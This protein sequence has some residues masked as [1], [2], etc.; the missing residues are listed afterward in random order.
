MPIIAIPFYSLDGLRAHTL[1]VSKLE[2]Q[3]NA[4]EKNDKIN[5]HTVPTSYFKWYVENAGKTLGD[6]KSRPQKF[7]T[8]FLDGVWHFSN[9]ITVQD[10]RELLN[11]IELNSNDFFSQYCEYLKTVQF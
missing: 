10:A 4:M 1:Y 2:Y 9:V 8:E 7:D 3:N 6:F 11:S 5:S